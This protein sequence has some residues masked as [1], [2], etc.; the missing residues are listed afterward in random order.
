[1]DTL[2]CDVM[3][4]T[5]H[6]PAVRV[7]CLDAAN[8]LLMLQWR[9]PADGS[10]LWEPPGGGIEPGETP[11]DTASRELVEETGLDPAAIGEKWTDVERDVRWNGQR[12]VG[13]EQFFLARFD[14][15]SPHISRAG[16]APD[17]KQNLRGHA[18]LTWSQ[19]KALDERV[20]PPQLKAVLRELA[21][22]GPWSPAAQ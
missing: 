7:I 6:R 1:V 8:R 12:F 10:T 11:R 13:A 16:L 22:G 9:D 17:E 15:D 21:P 4:N 20:E 3:D 18:W 14:T 19:L 5:R 2:P